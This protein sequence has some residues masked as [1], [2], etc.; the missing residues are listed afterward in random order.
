MEKYKV[1]DEKNKL[2]ILEEKK[3]KELKE[4]S[5]LLNDEKKAA[6]IKSEENKKILLQLKDIELELQ[7]YISADENEKRNLKEFEA[8]KKAISSYKKENSRTG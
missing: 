5:D 6:L 7:K 4:K 8:L 3:L 2:Y 1:Y